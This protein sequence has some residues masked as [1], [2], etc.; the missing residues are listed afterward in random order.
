MKWKKA[1][2]IANYCYQ[3]D[4]MCNLQVDARYGGGQTED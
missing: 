1:D 4:K 3:S 2:K